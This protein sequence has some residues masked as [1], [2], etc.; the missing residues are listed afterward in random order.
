VI[1]ITCAARGKHWGRFKSCG[2]ANHLNHFKER[3]ALTKRDIEHMPRRVR[4]C[5][6]RAQEG[7]YNLRN[8]HEIPSLRPIAK[9]NGRTARKSGVH[10]C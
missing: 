6:G 10:K 4:S 2:L 7:L 1:H 3:D 9:H 8:R 5:I